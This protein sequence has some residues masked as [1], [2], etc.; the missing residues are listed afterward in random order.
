MYNQTITTQR[1]VVASGKSALGPDIL[2]DQEC[3]IEQPDGDV[4]EGFDDS[5]AYEI[6]ICIIP[7][8][9]D[10]KLDDT[11]VDS[12]SNTYTV[13]GVQFFENPEIPNHT[14]LTLKRIL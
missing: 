1:Q 14:E 9:V 5:N 13:T 2:T 3:Y 4:A 6:F 10:A 7:E 12:D 11:V 8:I